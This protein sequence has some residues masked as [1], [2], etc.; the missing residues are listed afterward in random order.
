MNEAVKSDSTRFSW[1]SRESLPPQGQAVWDERVR[2]IAHGPTG[3]FNVMLRVP[4]LCKRVQDLEGFFRADSVITEVEREFITLVVV[5]QGNA[6][7]G[8]QRHE[9][10]AAERGVPREMVEKL[11]AVAPL[12]EFPQP[13]RLLVE[14]ARAL[15]GAREPLP[16]ELFRRV[17]A[18]KG[19]QWTVEAIALCAH[20]TLVGVL[21]N[22]YGVVPRPAENPTF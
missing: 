18:A 9:V 15:A 10:R 7:F 21:I 19:E 22:G 5:R 12:A 3:H 11:R 1:I 4:L 16:E 17:L 13:W 20:Y 6:R 14:L 2:T 8:W